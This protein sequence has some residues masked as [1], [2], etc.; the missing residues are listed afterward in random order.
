M[1]KILVTG[2]NGQLGSELKSLSN[3]YNYQFVFT[4]IEDLDITNQNHLKSFIKT[5]RINVIINCAAYT[6]VEKAE[7]ETESALKINHLAIKYLAEI[8]KKNQIKFIHISTDYVFDG[9]KKEPYIETDKTNPLSFYG[10]SKLKGEQEI[11]KINPGN[12]VII[13]TS[14]LYSNFGSNFVKSIVNNGNIKN[15]LNVVDDQVGS[16]TYANDLANVLLNIIPTIKNKDVEIYHYSNSGVCSW[17]QLSAEIINTLN[18][19]C[20]INPIK[21]SQLNLKA[22]RPMFSVLNT[23]KIKSKYKI[24]IPHW[25]V[26][27]NRCL[28]AKD[29]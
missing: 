8:A 22:K 4:D 17:Y 14:W 9:F 5:N 13:R 2:S 18:F 28:N 29:E 12:S 3:N 11:I 23:D 16:P 20:K 10:V 27:L 7:I 15:E 1:I 26:S 24:T 25:K 6:N 21:T 19:A